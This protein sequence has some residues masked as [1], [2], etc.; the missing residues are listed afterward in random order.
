MKIFKTNRQMAPHSTKIYLYSK[1]NY[2]SCG[3]AAYIGKKKKRLPAL[4]LTVVWCMEYI[5]NSQI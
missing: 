4:Q 3:E 5:N 2:H 1:Q